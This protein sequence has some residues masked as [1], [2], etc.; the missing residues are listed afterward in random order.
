LKQKK[1]LKTL[2]HGGHKW[3]FQRCS[4][5]QPVAFEVTFFSK[6]KGAKLGAKA[7]VSL[8][9]L[10]VPRF[11]EERPTRFG[12]HLWKELRSTTMQKRL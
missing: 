5:V 2:C 10:P 1:E 9:S 11:S 12:L 3:L 7:R 6:A 8:S 4:M